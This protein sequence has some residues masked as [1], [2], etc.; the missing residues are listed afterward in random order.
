MFIIIIHIN[1][2]FFKLIK[3]FSQSNKEE[4]LQ[5]IIIYQLNYITFFLLISVVPL[6]SILFIKKQYF[7]LYIFKK[8]SFLKNS[9]FSE[10]KICTKK[11]Y[12]W[13]D[14]SNE[15]K[16]AIEA[17]INCQNYEHRPDV[18]PAFLH[19]CSFTG[20]N[21][22]SQLSGITPEFTFRFH[23]VDTRQPRVADSINE[24]L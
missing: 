17:V 9:H 21:Q 3:F 22:P 7:N 10:P 4:S 18:A 11:H 23:F 12:L 19:W 24:T 8:E 2:W 1:N 13:N 20:I 6:N 16:N 15:K 14:L 5:Q